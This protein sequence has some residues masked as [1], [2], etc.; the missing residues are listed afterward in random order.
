MFRVFVQRH[1]FFG[2]QMVDIVDILYMLC[3]QLRL[4]P[5]TVIMETLLENES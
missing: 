4:N 1:N 5:L 2:F 3:L